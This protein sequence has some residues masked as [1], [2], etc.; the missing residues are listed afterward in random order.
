[1]ANYI[2]QIKRL[3]PAALKVTLRDATERAVAVPKAGNRWARCAQVIDALPWVT[4]EALDKDGRLLGVVENPEDDAESLDIDETGGV[5]L[6]AIAKVM[7]ELQR[8]TM[9]EMRQMFDGQ[10]RGMADVLQSMSDG[11]KA[12]TLTYREALTTQRQYLMAP[13][14]AEEAEGADVMRM[15]QMFMMMRAAPSAPTSST[16]PKEG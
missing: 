7:L 14:A 6:A 9:K 8:A 4:I 12:T 5:S 16:P 10:L 15:L 3:G 13:P 1:M 2:D 11:M